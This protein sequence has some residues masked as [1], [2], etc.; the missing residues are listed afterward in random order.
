MYQKMN[1]PI[2]GMIENMSYFLASDTGKKYDLFGN[3]G[4]RFEAEKI[5][6]PFLE[7]V[8]FDMDVRVLS[9]LGIPIVVHNMNSATSEIYQEIS[10]RIQQFFV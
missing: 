3:G 7:S 2:I 8:P 6:I 1:I 9:D 4:A 10:D 5:G